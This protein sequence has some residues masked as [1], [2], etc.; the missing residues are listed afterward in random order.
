[1]FSKTLGEKWKT[2]SGDHWYTYAE[3]FA[4][5]HLGLGEGKT[6]LIIGSPRSEVGEILSLGWKVTYMDIRK[7]PFEVNFVQA[8]ACDNPLPNESFDAVSSTCVLC[9][10]GTGR[11]GDATKENG[12]VSMLAHIHRVLNTG[13]KAVL[14][15]GPEGKEPTVDHRCYTREGAEGLMETLGFDVKD[16]RI[17]KGYVSIMGVKRVAATDQK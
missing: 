5:G 6:C 13:G 12:D 9:H 16:S 14:M 8:D 1:M 11:Y 2:N 3:E 7:P 17:L 10:A 4:A 15:F